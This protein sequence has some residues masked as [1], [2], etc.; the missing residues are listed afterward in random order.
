MLTPEQIAKR[1]YSV[2][3]SDANTIMSGDMKRITQLWKEKHGDLPPEDLSNVLPV[4]M[5]SFTEPL[6]VQWF[7]KQ[8]GRIVT[9]MGNEHTHP[10]YPHMTCTLDGLTDDGKTIFEAKHV[11]PFAK[12]DGLMDRYM[13]QLHHNMSV[14]GV[15]QAVLSVFFGNLRWEKYEVTYD[16]FYGAVVTDAVNRFWKSVQ[17]NVSPELVFAE[18]PKEFVQRMDMQN[19]NLWGHFAAQYVEMNPYKLKWDE[20]VA[21]M[22]ELVPDGVQ[23]A[24]GHGI[25]IK[26]DKR[27]VMRVRGE[28]N[29]HIQS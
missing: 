12:E 19:N 7:Q 28:K 3:G 5:G 4:V 24:Y 11:S 27:G 16:D 18:A 15:R 26:R 21:G 6:N 10:L 22:K 2:G 17:E 25:T 13:P 8:T 23:E 1:R 14:L 20:A 29:E 9:C